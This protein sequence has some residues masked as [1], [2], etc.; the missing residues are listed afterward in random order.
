MRRKRGQSNAKERAK[1]RMLLERRGNI[2]SVIRHACERGKGCVLMLG[3]IDSEIGNLASETLM[4]K[5]LEGCYVVTCNMLV[6][7]DCPCLTDVQ[8]EDDAVEEV[9]NNLTG[10]TGPS[11]VNFSSLIQ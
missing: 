7:E 9:A 5:C 8:A 1:V 3:G 6:F 2:C 4:R 11:G 10:G